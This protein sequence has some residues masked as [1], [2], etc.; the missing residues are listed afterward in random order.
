MDESLVDRRSHMIHRWCPTAV[1]I[2]LHFN[3]L[4]HVR[5]LA[6]QLQSLS[7]LTS[8]ALGSETMTLADVIRQID[9]LDDG[10]CVYAASR[11]RAESPALV[12]QE[13]RDGSLPTEAKGM[14]YLI[15]LRLAR[16]AIAARSAWCPEQELDIQDRCKAVIYYAVYDAPEPRPLAA[17]PG[18]EL[19][20]A[21]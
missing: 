8:T 6:R 5:S 1:Y 4:S 19:L 2:I 10:L 20:I 11:W 7:A 17:N 13:P 21:I 12:A 18:I 14:T 15:S 3:T 16:Q 9:Q